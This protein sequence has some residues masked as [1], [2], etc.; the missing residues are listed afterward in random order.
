MHAW[1]SQEY[2][3]SRTSFKSF[4][5][6]REHGSKFFWFRPWRRQL[7]LRHCD[8]EIDRLT[9]WQT[10]IWG[11]CFL[12]TSDNIFTN[13]YFILYKVNCTTEHYAI[14]KKCFASPT[15]LLTSY[16]LK[17]LLLCKIIIKDL[18]QKNSRFFL[19]C[20]F[21]IF[22]GPSLLEKFKWSCMDVTASQERK[23]MHI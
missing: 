16:P 17:T 19:L 9:Y 21:V 14:L 3:H 13:I 5:P 2:F 4:E 12:V 23:Y 10:E 6:Q 7:L 11:K 22:Y 1:N 15:S 20:K 18:I 8:G